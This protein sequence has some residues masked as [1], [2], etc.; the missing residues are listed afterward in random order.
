MDHHYEEPIINRT[1]ASAYQN[2]SYSKPPPLKATHQK[3]VHE[4]PKSGGVPGWLRVLVFVL[5]AVFLYYVYSTM[6][7]P[8]ENPFNGIEA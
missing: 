4:A 5:I 6:E 3:P 8:K 2:L 7:T 1:Q